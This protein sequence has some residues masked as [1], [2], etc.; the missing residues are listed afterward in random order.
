MTTG[1]PERSTM[2]KLIW[3]AL[4]PTPDSGPVFWIDGRGD[5]AAALPFLELPTQIEAL[6]AESS[7]RLRVA[8]DCNETPLTGR[9]FYLRRRDALEPLAEIAHCFGRIRTVEFLDVLREAGLE[10]S[11]AT[12]AFAKEH[13]TALI[14][15][16]DD[17]PDEA[18]K[19]NRLADGLAAAVCGVKTLD[20]VDLAVA[21]LRSRY[22]VRSLQLSRVGAS[23]GKIAAQSAAAVNETLTRA[24]ALSG[25]SPVEHELLHLSILADLMRSQRGESLVSH[26]LPA[27][28]RQ[29]ASR[30]AE[31]IAADAKLLKAVQGELG[32]ITDHLGIDIEGLDDATLL[33][34]R[35]VPQANEIAVQRLQSA[36]TSVAPANAWALLESISDIILSEEAF[37][38]YRTALECYHEMASTSAELKHTN[39]PP[40]WY[41]DRYAERWYRADEFYRR[42]MVS[43]SGG[44]K[45]ALQTRYRVWLR[46]L[47][48]AFSEALGTRE[49]WVFPNSQ[50]AIGKTFAH[51]DNRVAVVIMDALR[52]EMA[53]DLVSTLP[54]TVQC[55]LGTAVASLPSITEVGMSA[56]TPSSDAVRLEVSDKKLKVFVGARETTQKSARDELWKTSGFKVLGPQD[57]PL[58]GPSDDRVVVFHGAVDAI[59]EKLQAQFF[60]HAEQLVTQL[61]QMFKDLLQKGYEIVATADH[62]FLTLPPA[63]DSGRLPA[64]TTEDEVKKRRYRVSASEPL[65][66][67][68]I[69]RTASQLGFEGAVTVGFP[70]AASV[71]SAH[72]ASTFL[73]GGIS[74]QEL[75]IPHFRIRVKPKT[76]GEW[77]VTFPKKLNARAVRVA[78]VTP[79]TANVGKLVCLGVW[80]GAGKICEANAVVEQVGR[81]LT[82]TAYLPDET[83]PGEVSVKL[84][85]AGGAAI[86]EKLIVYDPQRM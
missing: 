47:N 52:L 42:A 55:D 9:L 1:I 18:L 14:V 79:S 73:H 36:L 4:Y 74:L 31:R 64:G 78:V 66:E 7:L 21:Q 28:V 58:L 86:E 22:V 29:V 26:L 32:S 77:S 67:P 23:D 82:V 19:T 70:P 39:E 61:S 6:T 43:V 53:R 85:I 20:P 17:I 49:S 80:A 33:K 50:R 37:E 59:G 81:Q 34:L 68:V 62:G 65:E 27:E 38:P 57:V 84:S 54:R 48:V 8:E 44:L 46:D 45:D 2:S 40:E 24:F 25:S 75:V 35:L 3:Y 13:A 16:W 60:D 83:P 72:G 63:D 11:A 30:L 15:R 5:F 51:L 12:V 41:L 71:L 10:I 56:L 76:V 69:S